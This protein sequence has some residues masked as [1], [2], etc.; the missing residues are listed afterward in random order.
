MKKKVI[1]IVM[2][3]IFFCFMGMTVGI[4]AVYADE[5]VR[6]GILT[7]ISGPA[8]PWGIIDSR[9][10]SLNAEMINERGG[11]KVKGETYK[12]KTII[13]DQKYI[14]AEAVKALNRAIYNDKVS[15]VAV[16]GGSPLLACIPLLKTNNM[17]SMNDAAGGKAV[18]NPDNPLVFRFNPGI[19]AYYAVGLKHLKENHGIKTVASI[20]PDDE[21]G[22]SAA[23][24]I[25][26]VN[27]KG[28]L[29]LDIMPS[30]YFERGSKDFSA[31]LTKI[32][33]KNPDVLET[34]MTDPTTQT[35]VAKQARELGFKGNIYLVWYPEPALLQK[36]A[37]PFAEGIFLGGSPAEPMT[38]E[39]KR[40]YAQFLKKYEAKD[41]NSGYYNQ[42]S[43]FNAL[44]MAIEKCQS[45]DSKT[46]ASTLENL[47]W[48]GGLGDYYWGGTEIFGIKR[49]MICPASL[50]TITNG[51][52]ILL[53]LTD[54][55]KGILE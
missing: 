1:G 42:G 24:A 15:Y 32:I 16:M 40:L 39:A 41:W 21:T 38:E 3:C 6:F 48:D 12:W 13:Y 4:N 26:Y 8:A 53:T 27:R 25:K 7:A 18:T 52:V 35:L 46:I 47:T 14:P 43:L 10:M 51:K 36:I 34:G 11:F 19:E 17:L 44:T 28:N 54:V 49:Q 23:E 31:I 33:A 5:E 50:R 30:E 45:F 37:G 20:N 29:G 22:R 2:V 9:A 55:P